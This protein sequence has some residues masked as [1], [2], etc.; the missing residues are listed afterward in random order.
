MKPRVPTTLRQRWSDWWEARLPRQDQIRLTQRNLYILPTRAGWSFAV[1][2]AV[3]LLASI[4]EQINLGY[5]LAFLLGGCGMAAIYQTHGNL[6]GVSLRLLSLHSVHAGEVLRLPVALNNQHRRLGRFGLQIGVD[7]RSLP[8]GA[9]ASS[10]PQHLDLPAG[11]EG[12][13]DVDLPTTQRGWLT[14]PRLTIE[15]RY[16]LGLLRAWAFWRPHSRVLVWPALDPHAP[17]LPETPGTDTRTPHTARL[18]RDA[19]MPEGLR[20][21][22]RGD[23][24]RWV[25]WKKSSRTLATSGTLVSREPTGGSAPERWLDYDLS[26]GLQ[27]LPLEARLSRL[28]SWLVQA[29]QDAT[30]S[31]TAYGL[32]LPG[33]TLGCGCGTHHLRRCLDTLA[34]WSPEHRPD[35]ARGQP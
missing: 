13:V 23:P 17:P 24:L 27:G 9:G 31:G 4:N 15:T 25:S 11:S 5:A 7:A 3:L 18:P 30:L 29:E 14:L 2:V 6:Q 35:T 21:H 26:P 20:D 22:R 12:S 32:R 19:D 10:P 33:D 16:P 34:T 28:A 1:V 8:R